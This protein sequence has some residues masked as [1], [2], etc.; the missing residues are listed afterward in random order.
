MADFTLGQIGTLGA[1][2]QSGSW[3]ILH[4]LAVEIFTHK[5]ELSKR[6]YRNEFL[7]GLFA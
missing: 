2:L 3:V 1:S 5:K 6:V 4:Y 7:I